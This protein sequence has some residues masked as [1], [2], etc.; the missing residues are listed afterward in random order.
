MRYRFP[1]ALIIVPIAVAGLASAQVV[2]GPGTIDWRGLTW[3]VDVNATAEVTPAGEMHIS[4]GGDTGDPAYDNWN[5]HAAVDSLFT[6][7]DYAL[8]AW[9]EFEFIDNG[10]QPDGEGGWKYGGGPRG[11]LDTHEENADGD[12]G[13]REY[14]FQGGMHDGFSDYYVNSAVYDTNANTNPGYDPNDWN[15][16]WTSSNWFY[17]GPRS[18]GIHTFRALLNSTTDTVDLWYDGVHMGT[19]SGY[20]T[21]NFFQTAFLG[22]TS[23][24]LNPGGPGY[25]VY[26]DFRWG[27]IPE[28]AS[29]VLM[30]L[31]LAALRRR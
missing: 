10:L 6:P 25:G 12:P 23:N 11:Y 7:A 28:P 27:V 19:L 26:T 4:V 2:D 20:D 5:V 16:G 15:T 3:T 17:P 30:V 31:A 14:M 8:G 29:A 21:P 13:S 24:G 22:V 18:A 9:I 1:L